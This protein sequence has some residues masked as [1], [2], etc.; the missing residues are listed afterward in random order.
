MGGGGSPGGRARSKNVPEVTAEGP[1]EIAEGAGEATL[2]ETA[3]HG[4]RWSFV[5]TVGKQGTRLL[6]LVVT[7]RIIGPRAFGI[8]GQASVYI[9]FIGLLRDQGLGTALVQKR[10]LGDR[11]AGAANLLSLA[12][13]AALSAAVWGGA[14]WIADFFDTSEL[15][16]VLRVLTVSVFAEALTVAPQS[17]L[18]RRLRFRAIAAGE[19]GG[20][21]VGSVAGIVAAV[22]GASYWSVVWQVVVM[23]CLTLAVFAVAAGRPRFRASKDALHDVWRMGIAVLGT[24]F[25][26]YV[27][28]NADYVTVGRFLGAKPLGFYSLSYRTMMIPVQNLGQVVNRVAFPLYARI[29][30]DRPRIGRQFLRSSRIIALLAF[31]LMALVA[32]SAPVG[33]PVV[34]GESWRPAVLTMQILAV[35]GA[36]QSLQTMVGPV[37]LACGRADWELRFTVVSTL[38]YVASFLIG[39]EWGIEGVAAAYTITG[40]AATPVLVSLAGRLTGLHLRDWLVALVPSVAG[41]AAL[42]AAYVAV[43]LP[44]DG[45]VPGIV[46]LG[47]ASAAG[48]AAYVLV[49]WRAWPDE[50][51]EAKGLLLHSTATA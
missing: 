15:T 2:R 50:I 36:R 16:A 29:Q 25:S 49:L 26:N 27:H 9:A 41:C 35:T 42:V 17:L 39:V 24:Q 10:V 14:P 12:L 51:T 19:V 44:L 43:L 33:V 11:D 18:M 34:F 8:A 21:V 5:A 40:L 3:V 30:D 20:A 22:L 45:E 1:E 23:D 6:F 28:R 37:L 48:L 32:V 46:T 31:P 47:A 4:A 7:A 38:A 13:A